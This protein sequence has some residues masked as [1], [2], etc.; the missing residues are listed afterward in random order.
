M[1]NKIPSPREIKP[2]TQYIAG[3]PKVNPTYASIQDTGI[4]KL[5]NKHLKTTNLI[6]YVF[7]SVI[8]TLQV[9]ILIKLAVL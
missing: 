8:I 6:F 5:R 1:K 2:Q 7:L 4:S 9:I 3:R